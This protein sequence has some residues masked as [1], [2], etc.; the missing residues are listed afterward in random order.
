[1]KPFLLLACLLSTAAFAGGAGPRPEITRRAA[2][3]AL[4]G[5]RVVE[6]PP[7][8]SARRTALSAA[9][10]RAQADYLRLRDDLYT[11][12]VQV[13]DQTERVTVSPLRS[14]G[15]NIVQLHTA[16]PRPTL[17]QQRALVQVGLGLFNL[18]QP[19]KAQAIGSP[20]WKARLAR[21]WGSWQEARV[22]HLKVGWRGHENVPT[23]QDKYFTGA[24]DL[25]WPA[26]TE[27]C[28]F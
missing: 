8:D 24:L 21:P 23:N 14:E 6:A 7:F 26:G 2:L 16:T 10:L 11:V 22:G 19:D 3:D 28:T 13:G 12:E 1:M 4:L 25:R 15:L 20:F 18:C 9:Q 5:V 17:S 27:R